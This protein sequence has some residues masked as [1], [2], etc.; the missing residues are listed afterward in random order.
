MKHLVGRITAPALVVALVALSAGP[1][2]ADITPPTP[3]RPPGTEGLTTL[4][5]WAC[6]S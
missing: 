6:G 3:T 1:A 2:A 5:N 4:L